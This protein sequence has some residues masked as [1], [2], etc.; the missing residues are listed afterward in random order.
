M[1]PLPEKIDELRLT[2]LRKAGSFGCRGYLS[3]ATDPTVIGAFEI[4]AWLHDRAGKGRADALALSA[5]GTN[6]HGAVAC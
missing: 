4:E 6:W 1:V 3:A 5:Q 2:I